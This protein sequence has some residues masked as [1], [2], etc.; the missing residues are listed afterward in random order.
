MPLAVDGTSRHEAS[1][2]HCTL[3]GISNLDQL[4]SW[5]LLGGSEEWATFYAVAQEVDFDQQ[6]L[7]ASK[8]VFQ[9]SFGDDRETLFFLCA[10]GKAQILMA[11]CKN[12]KAETSQAMV[13]WVCGRNRAHCLQIANFGLEATIDGWWEVVLPMGAIYRHIPAKR[14]IPDYGLHGVLRVTIC[15][16]SGMRD[17]VSATT[18]K[19][20]AVV[21]R[22]F[23]QPILDVARMPLVPV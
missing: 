16:I 15:G 5:W 19:S 1:Y 6:L 11:N 8:V 18:G 3:E 23:F 10:D 20:A 14:C 4:A 22:N 9:D 13:C 7:D 17:A 2:V 12:F 21:V